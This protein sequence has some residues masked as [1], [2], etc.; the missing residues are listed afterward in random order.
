MQNYSTD[1]DDIINL[2]HHVSKTRPQM[3]MQDRAAQ[4]SPFAALTGYGDAIKE[5]SRLVDEKILLDEEALEK[6]DLKFQ[7]LSKHLAERPEV[8]FTY[9]IPDEFKNGG[10]Y[11]DTAGIVKKIDPFRRLITLDDDTQIQMDDILEMQN[12][13]F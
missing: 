6:L 11:V 3:S 2:P 10:V 8:L 5:A 9:F 13:I 1:Y 4:F 7:V 12:K